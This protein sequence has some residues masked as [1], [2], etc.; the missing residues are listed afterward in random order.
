MRNKTTK[1]QSPLREKSFRLAIR[2]VKLYQHLKDKKKEFTLSKQILRSGTNPGAMV[3]EAGNAESSMDFVHKLAVAQK[4]L[5]ETQYWLDLLKA[6]NYLSEEEH[7]SI[8][9]DSEEVMKMVRSSIL[10]KKKNLKIKTISIILLL[11]TTVFFLV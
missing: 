6:T 11:A 10:T 2:I 4:E 7:Q 3:R 8:Y 9:S 5:G 1:P